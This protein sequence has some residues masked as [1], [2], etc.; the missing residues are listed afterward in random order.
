VPPRKPSNITI[1]SQRVEVGAKDEKSVPIQSQEDLS[2]QQAAT[3][4]PASQEPTDSKLK[5]T[6]RDQNPI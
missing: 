1:S 2:Q 5:S 4:K 3:Q 6:D